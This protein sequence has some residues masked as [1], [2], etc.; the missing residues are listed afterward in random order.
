MHVVVSG[1]SGYVG[2]ELLHHLTA[3][4]HTVVRLVRREAHGP[5]ESRWSPSDGD[6]DQTVIDS[7]DAI[8]NLSGASLARLP[9]TPRYRREILRSRLDTTRTLATAIT[10]SATPPT[11]FL[12]SSAV[13]YYGTRP[14]EVLTEESNAGTGF[15][16]EVVR[17][18]EDAARLAAPSTRVV[19][20][21]TGIVVGKGGA[22]TP[23]EALTRVGL[24]S[25][26]GDGT[27]HWPWISVHDE[28]AAI[29]HLLTSKLVGP[30][31]LA[32]PTPATSDQ[33]TRLLA[34]ALRRPRFWVIPRALIELVLGEAGRELLLPSRNILPARLLED[35]FA[36]REATIQSAIDA[37]WPARA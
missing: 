2:T 15:L 35:G 30:V 20:F 24:G 18:W 32:G 21:R 27:A 37:V 14:G 9:W 23:L 31:N 29:L 5:S 7:A 3:A 28:A 19:L 33:I 16:A 12:S 6:V 22:F 36:F 25:R 1:A 11:V 4:G 13:G 17:D 10:R 26:L 34:R 8:V